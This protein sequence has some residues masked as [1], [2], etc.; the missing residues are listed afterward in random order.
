MTSAPF[1]CKSFRRLCPTCATPP[2]LS[3]ATIPPIARDLSPYRTRPS[4]YGRAPP[5]WPGTTIVDICRHAP[6]VNDML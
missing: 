3:H 4:P 6:L 1:V 2:P 5:L